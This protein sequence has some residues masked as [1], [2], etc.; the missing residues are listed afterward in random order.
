VPFPEGR[1]A[2]SA[3]DAV[4]AA[5]AVGYP[6]AMKAQAAALSHKSDAGGVML[7]LSN[8]DAVRAAW[9]TM[10]R[11]VA[12]YSATITLD[13]VL[14]EAMGP[15]GMEMIVGGKNDPEWGSIVLA[16]FGGVTAEILQDVRLI[17]PDMDER[18]VIAELGRLK[19]AA[20]LHGYRGSPKLDVPALAKLIVTVARLLESE[21]RIA[22]LDLNP[23]ILY[24][25]GQGVKALDA[26]L[27]VTEDAG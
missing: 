9:E 17:T 13:G 19:S 5:D 24:P 11:S 22:E 21:H 8:A 14:I 10:H 6:V 12:A 2:A 27:L 18:A 7:N 23:V 15:R 4:L 16:G 3:D 20:L 26:L 25:E 1:F